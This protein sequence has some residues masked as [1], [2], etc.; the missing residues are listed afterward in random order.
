MFF[1]CSLSAAELFTLRFNETG[2]RER[3]RRLLF[4]QVLTK[5]NSTNVGQTF[6]CCVL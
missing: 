4:T 1:T 2:E 6:F 5:K 3:E